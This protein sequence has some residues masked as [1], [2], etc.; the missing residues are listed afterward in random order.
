MEGVC[1]EAG[2]SRGASEALESLLD[3]RQQSRDAGWPAE[4][5]FSEDLITD[6]RANEWNVTG[7]SRDANDLEMLAGGYKNF[8]NSNDRPT[9]SR[10]GQPH[11]IRIATQTGF[12]RSTRRAPGE[13]EVKLVKKNYGWPEDAKFSRPRWRL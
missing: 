13:A 7:T 5:S 4:W 12:L 3:L 1:C 9:P 10:R 6:S 2:F 11:R 8:L